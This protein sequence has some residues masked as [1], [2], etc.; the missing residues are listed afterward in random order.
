MTPQ[1]KIE[2]MLVPTDYSPCAD[3]AL[4]WAVLHART[5][6]AALT[7]LHVIEHHLHLSPAGVGDDLQEGDLEKDR[8]HL[9]SYVAERLGG[10]GVQVDHLVEIGEP[11]LRI[12]EVA[13]RIG[14]DLIIMG[15]HGRSRLQD[16][17]FN[18]VAG[19]VIYHTGCPVLAVPPLAEED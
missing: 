13:R 6:G 4:A 8:R 16:I 9:E 3:Q 19:K 2:R 12:R 15:T 14:A 1:P 18:S 5:F 7:V 11:H 10:A 17:L